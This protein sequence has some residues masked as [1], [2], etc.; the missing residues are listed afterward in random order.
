MPCGSAECEHARPD[1]RGKSEII[2][3]KKPTTAKPRLAVA[4]SNWNG[5][6]AHPMNDADSRPKNAWKML[7]V[8]INAEMHK[9]L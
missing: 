2:A 4:T 5:L 9:G 1:Y 3:P 6:S 8:R 7:R